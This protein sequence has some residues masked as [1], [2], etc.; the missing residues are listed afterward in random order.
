MHA[1]QKNSIL[2]RPVR[3]SSQANDENGPKQYQ[4]EQDRL[5]AKGQVQAAHEDRLRGAFYP[6]EEDKIKA[7]NVLER[8]VTLQVATR[9][10]EEARQKQQEA[11]WLAKS[12]PVHVEHSKPWSSTSLLATKETK[13]AR[14]AIECQTAEINKV[15]ATEKH[16]KDREDKQRDQQSYRQLIEGRD[17]W[18][19]RGV[20]SDDWLPPEQRVQRRSQP[21]AHLSFAPPPYY[22][23]ALD[24]KNQSSKSSTVNNVVASGNNT[25]TNVVV[26]AGLS[27]PG[28]GIN[29]GERMRQLFSDK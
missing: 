4:K 28:G 20:T 24:S 1:P 25:V 2:L 27:K 26:A 23:D 18:F 19:N 8:E 21:A 29:G 14:R 15:L 9:Q 16:V 7:A 6:T 11:A 13:E 3:N 17:T 22:C 12:L 5:N 10:E